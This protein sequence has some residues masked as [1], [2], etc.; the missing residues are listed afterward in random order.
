MMSLTRNNRSCS[1]VR[2]DIF[3]FCCITDMRRSYMMRHKLPGPYDDT[4]GPTTLTIMLMMSIT[5]QFTIKLFAMI[6]K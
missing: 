3:Y 4:I 1:I 2:Y 5:A 6:N